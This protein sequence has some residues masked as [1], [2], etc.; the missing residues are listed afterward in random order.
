MSVVSP[1]APTSSP[2][3]NTNAIQKTQ[4]MCRQPLPCLCTTSCPVLIKEEI[5]HT[6]PQTTSEGERLGAVLRRISEVFIIRE[7]LFKSGGRTTRAWRRMSTR[8]LYDWINKDRVENTSGNEN[9]IGNTL[10]RCV[11]LLFATQSIVT[12][13]SLASMSNFN[14]VV[15]F[16]GAQWGFPL[17]FGSLNSYDVTFEMKQDQSIHC[18]PIPADN[19][20]I[21][22]T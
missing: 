3:W 7:V 4:I 21:V 22:C 13:N 10:L 2:N 1:H 17:Y 12:L 6:H 15:L 9:K 19:D 5:H 8:P 18:W 16:S 20:T 14:G 11:C